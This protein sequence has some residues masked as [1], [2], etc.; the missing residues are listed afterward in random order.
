MIGVS[1]AVDMSII[2]YDKKHHICTVNGR[3]DAEVS[4][5]YEEWMEKHGKKKMT[6]KTTQSNGLVTDQKRFEIFKDN[7]RFID[8]HNN[9]NL[10]YKLRLT[11]FTD[12]TNDEFRSIYLGAKPKKRVLQTSDRYEPRVGDAR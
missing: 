12:L 2:S 6:T 5:I 4:K 9:K 8:E 3:S 11:P 7:L 1:Y 10:S